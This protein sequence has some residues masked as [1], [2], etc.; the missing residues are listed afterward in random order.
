LAILTPGR[1][2]E[3][4]LDF[5]EPVVID[6]SGE[7]DVATQQSARKSRLNV[8]VPE[9]ATVFV[10][11]RRTSSTGMHREY[12]LQTRR[13]GQPYR[14]R[15]VVQKNGL[16]LSETKLVILSPGSSAEMSFELDSD[17]AS[18]SEA[19]GEAVI[20]VHLIKELDARFAAPDG[21]NE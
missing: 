17:V 16:E 9:K 18:N 4:S 5:N 15:A 1:N 10:N 3:I 6:A 7:S 14:V 2:A 8:K 19:T 20:P 13:S 11:G 12:D 21:S